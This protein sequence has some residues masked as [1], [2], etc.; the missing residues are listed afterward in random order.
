[1]SPPTPRRI[2]TAHLPRAIRGYD[3]EATDELLREVSAYYEELWLERR[4]LRQQV[5]QFASEIEEL[6]DRERL[7]GEAVLTAE[8]AANEIRSAAQLDAE[9]ILQ[10]AKANAEGL[11][12]LAEQER[13][14]VESAVSRA[15]AVID[16]IRSDFSVLLA[17]AL[18][19]L[20]AEEVIR[21]S[22]AENGVSGE[23]LLLEDL[24]SKGQSAQE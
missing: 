1:V 16:K 24:T 19:R 8:R 15:R 18:E 14:Q 13:K 10:E 11:V 7:V 3:R 5:E 23:L 12:R 17:D 20:G 2:Q 6:R 22:E 21:E 4:A 9:A